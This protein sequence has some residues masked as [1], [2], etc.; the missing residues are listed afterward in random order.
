M[1]GRKLGIESGSNKFVMH[2]IFSLLNEGPILT[3]H[4]K[5]I[6]EFR[7]KSVSAAIHPV[8]FKK[9]ESLT[10]KYALL[11]PYSGGSIRLLAE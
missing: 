10:S 8:S 1:N 2:M 7:A 3:P 11:W 9:W 4:C 6:E 5:M